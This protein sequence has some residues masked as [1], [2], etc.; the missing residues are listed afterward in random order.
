M[1]QASEHSPLNPPFRPGTFLYLQQ[2]DVKRCGGLDMPATMVAVEKAF[3]LYDR[4][5]VQEYHARPIHWGNRAGRRVALHPSYIGGDVEVVGIKWIP[6]NPENPATL[7][8]PRSNALIIVTDPQTGYPLGVVEGKIISDMRTG[9]VAGLGARYLAR[10]GARRVGLIGGGP[11]NRTHLM[12]LHHVLP[13]L[14]EVKI[15]DIVRA[16][17]ERYVL[18]MCRRLNVSAS[19]FRVVESAEAA[20][21]DSDVVATA[22]NVNAQQSY[23]PSGWLSRGALLINTSVND[24]TM[25]VVEKAD[26]VVVDSRHQ[27]ASEGTRLVEAIRA[28]LFNP[29]DAVELGAIINGKHPGRRSPHETIL[30]CP[31]GMGMNDLINAK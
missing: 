9:A 27:F 24:P 31:L 6:S 26:L 10:P 18:D 20:V 4:G 29:A 19:L 17:A 13:G 2:E 8:L 7:R 30:F 1:S 21:R 28:G 15:Y 25:D 3:S 23:L 22:T 11:I 16:N 5:L 12:A 14:E